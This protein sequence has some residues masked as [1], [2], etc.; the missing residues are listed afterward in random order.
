MPCIFCKICAR[1]VPTKILYE[2]D[3]VLAF[4]DIN[5]LCE[6]HILVVPKEHIATLKDVALNNEKQQLI[7]GRL[8]QVAHQIAG[9]NGSPE[10]CRLIINNG[11]IGGQE[12]QHLHL[13]ILG[14]SKKVGAMVSKKLI[15]PSA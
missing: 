1:E 8:V 9:E 13:H 3:L 15:S 5:P 2:D 12:V 4:P 6:V 11:E 10:G 14:G 7:L